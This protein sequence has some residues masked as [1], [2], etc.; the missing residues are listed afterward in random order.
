MKS[1]TKA[2]PGRRS[3]FGLRGRRL[4]LDVFVEHPETLPLTLLV[5]AVV[6]FWI[7]S[8][9]FLSALNISSLFSF[10]PELGLIALGMTLL[11]TAGQFDLSVGAV[12]GFAP[13]LTFILANDEGVPLTLAA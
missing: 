12:F 7:K 1:D 8:S 9:P 4:S 13:L 5:I 10:I 2:P 11:L 6:A 3:T